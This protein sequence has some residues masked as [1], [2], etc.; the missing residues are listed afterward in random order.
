MCG[1]K[2]GCDVAYLAA[3]YIVIWP[4]G[5]YNY[6][7][8]SNVAYVAV[9]GQQYGLYSC[10]ICSNIAHT[11]VRHVAIMAYIRKTGKYFFFTF[12]LLFLL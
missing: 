1:Y 7:R 4:I 3:R 6:K 12:F 11:A 9:R 2:R 10:E 8:G 5:L